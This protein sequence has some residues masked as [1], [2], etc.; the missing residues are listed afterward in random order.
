MDEKI[1]ETET[2]EHYRRH[3]TLGFVPGCP[4]CVRLCKLRFDMTIREWYAFGGV[5][6]KRADGK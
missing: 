1:S 4:V 3:H 5:W 2:D 6:I